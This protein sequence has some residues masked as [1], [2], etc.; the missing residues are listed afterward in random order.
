MCKDL[1]IEVE[2]FDKSKSRLASCKDPFLLVEC[3]YMHIHRV[4]RLEGKVLIQGS[5]LK[6]VS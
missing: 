4:I 5:R 1:Y 3:E 2:D 6:N